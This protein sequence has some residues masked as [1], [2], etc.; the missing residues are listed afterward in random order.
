[1]L[2]ALRKRVTVL[3]GG[4]IEITAPELK[5]GTE[6][7]VII[8]EG[9]GPSDGPSLRSLIGTGKGAF[10]TPGEADAFIRRERDAWE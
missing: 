9:S 3:P 8:L 4:R 5:P 10:P 6:A 2:Y 1:M 7:E